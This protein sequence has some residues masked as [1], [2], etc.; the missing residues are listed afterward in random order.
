MKYLN[1][2]LDSD[3]KFVAL[4]RKH[5][6][7]LTFPSAKVIIAIAIAVLFYG[8][9]AE[10][11]YGRE[12]A[13]IWIIASI[14]YG[15]YEI[16]IWYLD[17]FIITNK[18]IIDINQKGLFKR[19]VAEADI[20]NIQEAIYEISGPLEA[21]FNFGTIKIKTAGTGSIIAMEQIPNPADLRNFILKERKGKK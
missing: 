5:W 2:E 11:N 4:V 3:E 10:F 13:F 20:N 21:I 16:I 15:V 6:I 19:V 1:Y 14:L 9:A 17:C 18:R 8:K 7:T 12:I